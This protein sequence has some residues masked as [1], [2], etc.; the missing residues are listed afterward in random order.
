MPCRV[1][2]GDLAARA[3]AGIEP[4]DDM[5]CER[6]LEEQL[7]QVLTK[8]FDCLFLRLFGET[9]AQLAL[10]RGEE[11]AFIPVLDGGA[12]LR[13]K[14][15]RLPEDTASNRFDIFLVFDIDA[16]GET[17]F[18]LTAVDGEDAVRRQRAHGF[19]VL[20][21]HLECLRV[22]RRR[23]QRRLKDGIFPKIFTHLR[24]Q[25]CVVH[26]GLGE[27]IA[28]TRECVC[29]R[30][31]LLRGIYKGGGVLLGRPGCFLLHE[32]GVCERFQSARPCDRRPRTLLLLVGAIEILQRLQFFR[33]FN[34]GAQ[35]VR[36]FALLLDA[37]EDFLLS[38]DETAQIAQ[39]CLDTAQRFIIE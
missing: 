35:L 21:V 38:F 1:D 11:Q 22:L 32:H 25:R 15:R 36:E 31:Y 6:R 20:V 10:Q 19:A 7:F 37:R 16:Y 33:R 3:V 39:P 26:D 24:A 17:A 4:H 23:V 8:D 5:S 27:N 18:L 34:G 30:P 14:D 28:R 13:G 9:R 12:Q 29:R 2:D